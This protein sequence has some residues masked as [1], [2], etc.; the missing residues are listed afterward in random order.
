MNYINRHKP[1][2]KLTH[3]WGFWKGGPAVFSVNL[4]MGLM[5][6]LAKFSFRALRLPE[7]EKRESNTEEMIKLIPH[8]SSE[9]SVI[10]ND[11]NHEMRRHKDWVDD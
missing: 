3:M 10:E 4:V 11:T 1:G 6:G 9:W 8:D 2:G 5:G 7:R